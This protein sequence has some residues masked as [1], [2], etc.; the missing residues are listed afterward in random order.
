MEKK[1]KEEMKLNVQTQTLIE[2]QR[3]TLQKN[4]KLLKD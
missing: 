1:F 2:E 3:G 4:I